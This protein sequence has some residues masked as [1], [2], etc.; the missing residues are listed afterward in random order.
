MMTVNLHCRISGKPGRF[1]AVQEFVDF[2]TQQQGIW[3]TTKKEV[4][5]HFRDKF[6][7]ENR[8]GNNDGN[9]GRKMR[10]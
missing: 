8:P 9:D 6:P 2:L 10:C 1:S 5:K 4:A 7:Y 3:I